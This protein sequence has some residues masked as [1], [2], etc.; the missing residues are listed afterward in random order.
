VLT[1]ASLLGTPPTI[2]FFGKILTFYV[3]SHAGALELAIVTTS[4]LVLLIF[5]I[6]TVRTRGIF[7]KQ[8]VGASVTPNTAAST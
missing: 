2:G 4:T 1:L 3:L 6:Q 8:R 7:K 5:Y